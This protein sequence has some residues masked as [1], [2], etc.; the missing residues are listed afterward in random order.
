MKI[1]ITGASGSGTRTLG[2]KISEEFKIQHFDTDDFFWA[3]SSL[4]YQFS[5]DK[6]ERRNLL[7]SAL[8]S[9][10]NW[11]LSGS[12]CGWA[13][14]A[15]PLFDLVIFL[16]VPTEIRIERLRIREIEKFGQQSLS[17][18]GEMHESHNEFIKWASEYDTGN[19]EMRSKAMHEAW[20]KKIE[21][22]IVRYEGVFSTSKIIQDITD[23]VRL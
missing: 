6:K 12:L 3:P 23:R 13:D 17:P 7:K 1:H 5:R 20:L 2:R 11:V 21:C 16:L 14:F 10:T 18:G 19:D 22:E 15:I 9:K 4:P 8:S